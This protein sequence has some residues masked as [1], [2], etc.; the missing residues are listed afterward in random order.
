MAG[1]VAQVN[2]L[3]AS[4]AYSVALSAVNDKSCTLVHGSNLLASHFADLSVSMARYP[5]S[6]QNIFT[7]GHS[8]V[9]R[10]HANTG[11]LNFHR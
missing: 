7:G 9:S 6:F 11:R 4:A 8:E 5:A 2:A 1:F 3:A 10:L